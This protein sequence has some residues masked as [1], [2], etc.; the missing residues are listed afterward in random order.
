MLRLS[1]L[2]LLFALLA[3]CA[4]RQASGPPAPAW[5]Y[6]VVVAGDTLYGIAGRYGVSVEAIQQANGLSGTTIHPGMRLRIPPAPA[7]T[8]GGEYVEVGIA[9]WY[10]PNFNG[11]KTASGEIYD[12]NALTAA[13]RTL[14]FGTLVQ[15]TRL[16]NGA[17]VVVRI[18][19]RGPFKK[20]RIID[21][22]YAAA[23]QIGLIKSGTALVRIEVV[24]WSE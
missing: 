20:N 22:S 3:S 11:K 17:S 4:P 2:V 23:R 18:N 1:F 15:V 10:G 13:H 7:T 24:A 6:Y 12:M 21:L 5:R 16:D 19:D 8:K 14:P 9:S